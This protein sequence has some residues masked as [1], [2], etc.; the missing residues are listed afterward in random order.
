MW[1]RVW[2]GHVGVVRR[3]LDWLVGGLVVTG[4]WDWRLESGP[5][6]SFKVGKVADFSVV[7]YGSTVEVGLGGGVDGI[8]GRRER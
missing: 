2:W 5:L 4:G 8:V 7:A 6:M 1:S 3:P